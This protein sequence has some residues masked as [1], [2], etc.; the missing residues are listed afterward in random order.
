MRL[1]NNNNITCMYNSDLYVLYI[2][3][4]GAVLHLKLVS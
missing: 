3:L 4:A 1:T 2:T